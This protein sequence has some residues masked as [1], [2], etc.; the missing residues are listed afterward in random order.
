[1]TVFAD[2][3]VGVPYLEIDIDREAIARYGL[4]IADVQAVIEVAVGGVP[5]TTTVEGRERY[6]VRVRYM[7]ELRDQIDSLERILI[8]TAEGQQIPLGQLAKVRYERGPQMI[9]SEDTFLVG[10][11]LFD[12]KE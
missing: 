10:Y 12:K 6:P 8:P 3:I 1:E 11:V 5:L 7:R 2:R 9:K 4:R